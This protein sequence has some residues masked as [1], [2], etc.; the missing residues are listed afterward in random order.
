MYIIGEEE[1]NAVREVIRSGQLF[2]YGDPSDGHQNNVVHFEKEW[3]EYNNVKYC[4]CVTSGSAALICA[5]AALGIGPGDEVIIPGYTYIATALTV[6]NVG[7]I[8]VIADV[9]ESCTLNPESARKLI[10]ER[11]KAII[12]VH[13]MGMPCNLDAISAIAKEHKLHL[14]EDACQANGGFY[15]GQHLGTFG[16]LGAFSFNYYKI[17]SAGESGAVITND[18]RLFE[19]AFMQHDGG[20]QLWAQVQ[21]MKEDAYAGNNFRNNEINAS[22]LRVQLK[23]LP[24]IISRLNHAK[25]RFH[26]GLIKSDKIWLAP[27]NDLAG[28][29]GVQTTLTT[30]SASIT[31]RFLSEIQEHIETFSPIDTGRHVYSNWQPLM[32]KKGAHHPLMDPFLMPA[33]Q[34][35]QMDYTPQMLPQTLDILSRS[36]MLKND[37]HWSDADIDQKIDVVNTV[38]RTL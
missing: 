29:C 38:I 25:Q 13:M 20:C 28:D 2:R 19:R 8:P 22:I 10:S 17:I 30:A 5:M 3:A 6:L 4:V 34:G 15:K 33:N 16:A 27:C 14:I 9:D 11:T 21:D 36:L 35:A 18:E 31:K 26:E 12:S 1:I 32:N 23:R 37:V 24:G 7:A